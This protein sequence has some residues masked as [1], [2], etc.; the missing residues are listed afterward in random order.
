MA[1]IPVPNT[2]RFEVIFNS[3][4]QIVENVYHVEKATPWSAANLETMANAIVAWWKAEMAPLV[5]SSVSLM[6]VDS[7]DLTVEAAPF[8][9]APCLVDC[10]GTLADAQEP[11]NVTVAVKWTGGLTGRS[12]RGR[13][14]HIGLTSGQVTGNSV[15]IL[16]GASIL[17]AYNELK[18]SIAAALIGAKLVIVSYITGG[19]P[20]TTGQTTD[21]TSASLDL[22]I[23]SQRRRLPGRGS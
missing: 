12:Q 16:D 9:S 22:T 17:A 3:L 1:F 15:D 2:A 18:A 21:V 10:E 4:D 6:R 19:V 23:D 5:P 13:T 20:R 8:H 11:N 14:Y 7:R